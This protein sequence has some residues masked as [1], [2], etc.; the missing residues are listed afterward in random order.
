MDVGRDPRARAVDVLRRH[1][2]RDDVVEARHDVHR[3]V[4][5]H[6]ARRRGRAPD[7][8]PRARVLA[9]RLHDEP[10][11]RRRHRRAGV[12]RVGGRRRAAGASSTAVPP[13]CSSRT[14]TSGRARSGLPGCE[15]SITTSPGSG[16]RTATTTA[17]TPGS[18][19]ATKETDKVSRVTGT[20]AARRGNRRPSSASPRDRPRQD[21]SARASREPSA[22]SRRPALRR[23][24]HRAR[25]LHRVTLVLGRVGAR[26]LERVRAHGR[27]TRRRRGL[28]VPARRRR[29][30]RRA[31]SA[32]PDRWLVRVGRRLA[33]AARRRRLRRR[34]AHGDA[35]TRTSNAAG[36]RS[37]ASSCRCARPTICTTPA[38]SPGPETTIVYTRVRAA[39]LRSS[40][41]A[42]HDRRHPAPNRA[43]HPCVRV[44]LVR[45]LRCR[46]RRAHALN[47]AAEHIRVERF[48]PSA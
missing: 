47:V 24:A 43:G 37:C 22:S 28:D 46:E 33:G 35:A 9:H 42:A 29:R 27:T 23:A 3:R 4:D 16:S 34:A 38:S 15:C 48:G 45:L 12:G 8:D 31:R 13:A 19:S 2:L 25:R 44:W 5:R 18:S 32:R 30:R 6:V 11:A 40:A 20:R 39:R 26:R 21:V 41:G 1:P 10:A 36:R 14:S 17:A 7:R